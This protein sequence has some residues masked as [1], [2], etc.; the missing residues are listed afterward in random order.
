LTATLRYV[1]VAVNDALGGCGGL[2]VVTVLVVEFVRPLLSVTVRV[3]VLDP[4][5][6][7]VCVAVTPVP[8]VPSPQFHAYDDIVP[9]GS[10]DA[11]AFT[12]TFRYVTVAVNDATG[13]CGGLTVVTVCDVVPVKPL[14]SVTVN[15][16]VLDPAVA[17][18]CVAVTPV[19]VV[20]SPQAHA[21]NDI[22]PSGSDDAAALTA[23]L[24][25]VTVAVNDATGGCGGLTVVT[26]LVVVPVMPL[27]SVTV[28]VIVLDPAV[29]YVCVAVTPVPLAV[30]SPQFHAYDDIVPSGSDDAAALT[31][32]LR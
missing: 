8:V 7:Y 18:V 5:V 2:T 1:T 20:P 15:V 29:A 12:E 25:Y 22:V 10:D 16:I 31:A 9:S 17:Y 3:I 26:V 13:G 11:A 21:Y 28:N 24:R 14:L 23:T 27:L 19:P 32:T 6:A 30:P 4:A